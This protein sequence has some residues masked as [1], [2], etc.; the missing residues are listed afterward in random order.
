MG[1]MENPTWSLEKKGS[2]SMKSRAKRYVLFL[3][4][5]VTG[6][7]V[8]TFVVLQVLVKMLASPVNPA[9]I[10]TIQGTYAIKPKQ[11]PAVPGNEGVGIVV[12]SELNSASSANLQVGDWVIPATPGLGTWQAYVTGGISDFI[13]V[14]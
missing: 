11:L 12:H 14:T 10:N 3:R 6:F 13:K 2:G 7:L 5:T 1:S 8:I 4:F 9:D